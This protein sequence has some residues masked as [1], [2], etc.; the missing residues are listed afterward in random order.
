MKL[1]FPNGEHA[2]VDLAEGRWTIGSAADCAIVVALPGVA[3]R[4]AQFQIKNGIASVQPLAPDA[5]VAVNGRPVAA[6]TP[7]KPG[8]L[9]TV[10]TV[11]CRLAAVER[12]GAVAP[13]AAR[14]AV[15]ESGSTR[16]RIALPRFV[17]RGVSGP[18]FGKAFPIHGTMTIG[19]QADCDITVA[20]E[21]VSRHH[22]RVQATVEGLLVEDLG[23]ANGT[24]IGGK[25]VQSG[26]L[27]TG[28]ELR[29][30]TVR[31]L[32]LTPGAELQHGTGGATAGETPAAGASPA[33]TGLLIGVAIAGIALVAAALWFG[34]VIPH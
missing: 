3:A 11:G 30:D 2:S 4:H 22:A 16:L 1:I 28:E 32:L 29:L 26:L 18:T 10:A 23:S 12:A 7:L 6:E 24:Y 21:E 25:R 15:D 27:K 5:P 31:F 8:D 9:I 13:A 17:L 33:R 14:P 20:T 19:R 34:G